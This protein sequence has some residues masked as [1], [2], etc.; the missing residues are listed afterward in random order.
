MSWFASTRPTAVGHRGWRAVLDDQDA[1]RPHA[2]ATRHGIQ[3]ACT[4]S[5]Q[6]TTGRPRCLDSAPNIEIRTV[7][8]DSA[9][10]KVAAHSGGTAR[11]YQGTAARRRPSRRVRFSAAT[12]TYLTRVPDP[13]GYKVSLF[14]LFS[15]LREQR[16][17]SGGCPG[18][19]AEP[20]RLSIRQQPAASRRRTPV[21]YHRTIWCLGVMSTTTR[22]F[23]VSCVAL[24]TRSRQ[25]TNRQTIPSTRPAATGSTTCCASTPPRRPR[26]TR[27]M[28]DAPQRCSGCS[29]GTCT[30]PR[31][32]AGAWNPP[33]RRI[34]LGVTPPH[35]QPLPFAA[36]HQALA[37][38]DAE[39]ENLG[40]T[41]RQRAA[42]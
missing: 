7:T 12:R 29:P 16:R 19:A 30:R 33:Q 13:P 26:R 28:P 42:G 15:E 34:P 38:C 35:C 4:R 6:S 37:W 8:S 11:D 22:V 5:A 27:E 40:R 1:A 14:C 24:R 39:H 17:S 25:A 3:H 21:R 23:L 9:T 2:R 10:T 32:P 31:P 41:Q 18:M 36:H 20:R